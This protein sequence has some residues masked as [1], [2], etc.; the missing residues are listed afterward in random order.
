MLYFSEVN[1]NFKIT[2]YSSALS[3]NFDKTRQISVDLYINIM[4]KIS[5]ADRP[6]VTRYND[7][8]RST[9]A[10]QHSDYSSGFPQHTYHKLS[11]TVCLCRLTLLDHHFPV[12]VFVFKRGRH[13]D[14]ENSTSRETNG[15]GREKQYESC[16]TE[17]KGLKWYFYQQSERGGPC[18]DG[19]GLRGW[20][21]LWGQEMRIR[22][23]KGGRERDTCSDKYL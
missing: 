18:G 12:F 5:Q 13:N 17:E 16:I 8:V 6:S 19:R 21:L 23:A 3:Q 7:E 1:N 14:S 2:F 22:G 10:I 4:Y 9:P 11:A 15:G 20:K